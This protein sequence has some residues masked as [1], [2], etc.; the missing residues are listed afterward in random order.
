VVAAGTQ[1][2]PGGELALQAACNWVT[3]EFGQDALVFIPRE[4]RLASLPQGPRYVEVGRLQA[5]MSEF[6]GLHT[7]CGVYVGMGDRLPMFSR[8][9]RSVLVIQNANIYAT[10]GPGEPL[11]LRAQYRI[12]RWWA[13]ISFRRADRVV[14]S[15][16]AAADLVLA[17][18]G[19]DGAK[20]HVVAIPPV[21]TAPPRTSQSTRIDSIFLVGEVRPNKRFTWALGEISRWSASRGGHVRVVHVGNV[22]A[23]DY[24]RGFRS[25]AAGL[26]NAEVEL[27]GPMRHAEAMDALAKADL[28]VFPS[29]LESHGLPLSEAM[30]SGVPVLCSDI[31]A[32]RE[33]GEAAPVY[34]SGL[35]GT[36]ECAL[37]AVEAVEVRERMAAVGL[38]L[39]PRDGA[40]R[41]LEAAG[42]QVTAGSP[43]VAATTDGPLDSTP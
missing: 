20:M 2:A 26:A 28:L 6:F 3:E 15:T 34:F 1:T 12:Q 22:P 42:P 39:V 10:P 17:R 24:G 13:A 19:A 30:A 36:L 25:E 40:W 16:S 32:F 11:R 23:T 38:A 29:R 21:Q 31:P 43:R 37:A 8:A 18:L 41:L 5:V 33:V 27:R 7:R 14:A 35:D 9:A 4:L